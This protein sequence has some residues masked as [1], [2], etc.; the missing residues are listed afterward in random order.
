VIRRCEAEGCDMRLRPGNR[1]GFCYQHS[2]P[3]PEGPDV[4]PQAGRRPTLE[5]PVHRTRREYDPRRDR[6]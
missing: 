3:P 4:R 2:G 5:A 6:G 1:S